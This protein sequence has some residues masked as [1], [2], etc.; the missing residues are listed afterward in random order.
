MMSL[1]LRILQRRFKELSLRLD[2]AYA[3]EIALIIDE[4]RR[5]T[6]ILAALLASR[7]PSD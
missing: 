5:L 3:H 4:A 7:R 1:Q 6:A 2:H